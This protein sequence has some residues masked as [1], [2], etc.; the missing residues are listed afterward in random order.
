MSRIK[1]LFRWAIILVATSTASTAASQSDPLNGTWT[2]NVSRSI[3]PLA[4]AP[5]K[6]QTVTFEGTG[7]T[8]NVVSVT[9]D[10]RGKSSTFTVKHI[11]DGQPHTASGSPYFDALAYTRIDA[12]TIIFT[13]MRGGKLTG[14]GSFLVSPD[15]R[16]L[17]TSHT[18]LE[19]A[20]GNYGLSFDKQ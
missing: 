12:R 3:F 13:R 19:D 2:L 5:P 18:G 8:K 20:G 14:I 10:G 1:V 6:S 11:Y 4:G 15:G 9:V 16:T 17:T 7:A